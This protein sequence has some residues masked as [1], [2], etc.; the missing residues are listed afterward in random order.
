MQSAQKSGNTAAK[1]SAERVPPIS[2]DR[3][4]PS[5]P[6]KLTNISRQNNNVRPNNHVRP[7]QRI[8]PKEQIQQFASNLRRS[9]T[10]WVLQ[11]NV[12]TGI[13]WKQILRNRFVYLTQFAEQCGRNQF[14][15]IDL[16]R[17]A[18]QTILETCRNWKSDVKDRA[19]YTEIKEKL[20]KLIASKKSPRQ[21]WLFQIAY[22]WLKSLGNEI[23][24][25][26]W[27]PE[28]AILV[29]H[30]IFASSGK[31]K[32]FLNYVKRDARRRQPVISMLI[33]AH[34]SVYG[35]EVIPAWRLK[36]KKRAEM[37]LYQSPHMIRTTYIPAPSLPVFVPPSSGR[38][39]TLGAVAALLADAKRVSK[40]DVKAIS[41]ADTKT[42][43]TKAVLGSSTNSVSGADTKVVSKSDTKSVSR[44]DPKSVSGANV[45]AASNTSS[46]PVC[47]DVAMPKKR[48][49]SGSHD[50]DADALRSAAA[51]ATARA[52]KLRKERNSLVTKVPRTPVH[53][54]PTRCLLFIRCCRLF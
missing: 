38:A 22:F 21:D 13:E 32:S 45:A 46:Q 50:S 16:E 48:K 7:T 49:I 41:R 40:T 29:A 33:R 18:D 23:K 42:V 51:K 52:E 6:P 28:H 9:V 39:Q 12:R 8:I 1:S 26:V 30:A 3:T 53:I 47:V 34:E 37:S 4:Y 2:S 17:A 31:F 25:A 20:K 36:Y 11:S 14:W 43:D 15:Q 44:T 24:N 27:Y 5:Q 35:V 10:R 19:K 54:K